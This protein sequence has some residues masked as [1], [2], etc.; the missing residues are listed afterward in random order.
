MD[1]NDFDV[2]S[3]IDPEHI[4]RYEGLDLL[5][6]GNRIREWRERKGFTTT[7]D[8]MAEKLLL[9]ISEVIEATEDHRDGKLSTYFTEKGKPCGFASEIADVFI[10][11]L[12]ITASMDI[13]ID[14]E[15][16]LKMAFNETRPH[17]HGKAY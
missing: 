5:T 17:K 3:I 2:P 14:Y 13:D 7:N 6:L 11:L 15:I 10:R 8:N 4:V 16:A 9:V 1:I 12:D